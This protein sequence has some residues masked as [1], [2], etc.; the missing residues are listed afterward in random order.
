[1]GIRPTGIKRSGD[2]AVNL[3]DNL[4]T[5]F[6]TIAKQIRDKIQLEMS[7]SVTNISNQIE[8]RCYFEQNKIL[9]FWK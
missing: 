4:D 9:T 1:M 6:L 2:F 8:K 7:I 5:F 3:E